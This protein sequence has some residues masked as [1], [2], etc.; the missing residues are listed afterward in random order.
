MGAVDDGG[1]LRDIAMLMHAR[2]HRAAI[3]VSLYAVGVD[4][5]GGRLSLGIRTQHFSSCYSYYSVFPTSSRKYLRCH[6]V[7][8]MLFPDVAVLGV[9]GKTTDVGVRLKMALQRGEGGNASITSFRGEGKIKT[10]TKIPPNEEFRTKYLSKF[11]RVHK[12]WQ[13]I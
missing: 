10:G 2:S 13:L 1:S 5:G 6:L 3:R 4:C 7:R 12:K 8:I 11:I 9:F